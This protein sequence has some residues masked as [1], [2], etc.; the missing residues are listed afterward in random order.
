ME[1]IFVKVLAALVLPPGANIVLVLAAL[2]IWPRARVL[3]ALLI[4]VSFASLV[5]L[6]TP[7]FADVLFE[8]LETY[9][10]RLPGAVAADTIGAIV[11]LGGGSSGNAPE[12]G[13]Q[14]I[15]HGTLV[16]VRYAAKLQRE[17]GLPILVSGGSVFGGT[18]PEAVLMRDALE[19]DFNAPV[20]WLEDRSRTTAENAKLTAEL[21]TREG[22]TAILLV[23]HAMHMPR[24]VEAF[25]KQGV[26]VYPAP[27]GFRFN[28]RKNAAVLDW[29]PSAGALEKSQT[30]LHEYLGRLWYAIRY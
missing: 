8:G 1:L 12:Y 17:T 6:S 20:R 18:T 13:G 14:T 21:L 30:A 16:R 4:T 11:V 15:S 7:R 3:A 26:R 2:V 24:A 19:D 22:I 23:T 9:E 29:L 10:P 25:E 27:T 28:V 5:L